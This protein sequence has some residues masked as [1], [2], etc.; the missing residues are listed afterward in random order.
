MSKLILIVVLFFTFSFKSTVYIKTASVSID[1]KSQ[2]FIKGKTNINNF[3][4]TFNIKNIDN[5]ISIHYKIIDDNILFEKAHLVLDNHCFDC[6]H[7]GMNRDF[8]NLLKSDEYPEILLELKEINKNTDDPCVVN[9]ITKLHIAGKSKVYTIPIQ[10]KED[11]S[12]MVTGNLTLNMTDFG[13][14][15]PKKALGLIVVS[16]EIEI[17]FDMVFKN[18]EF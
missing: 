17:K 9:A 16:D 5:P 14:E 7:K 11:K 1:P 12:I 2:I 3:I 4:C 10:L 8:Y 18:C 15:A 6:G 13:L